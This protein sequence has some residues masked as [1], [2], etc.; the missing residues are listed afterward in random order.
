MTDLPCTGEPAQKAVVYIVTADRLYAAE[1]LVTDF[2][3][4]A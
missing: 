4:A 2:Y 3:A 1:V